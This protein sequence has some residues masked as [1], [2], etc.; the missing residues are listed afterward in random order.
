MREAKILFLAANPV[1]S[2]RLSLDEGVR[3][4]RERIQRRSCTISLD[5]ESHWA[6]RPAD[7]QRLLNELRPD[8][9]HFSG[10][11]GGASGLMFH[12]GKRSSKMIDGPTLRELF[13]LFREHVRIVV[14]NACYSEAQAR[15]ISKEIDWVVGM[16][17]AVGDRAA[18]EFA[19]GFYQALAYGQN[20]R[21]AVEQGRIAMKLDGLNGPESPCLLVRRGAASELALGKP[22]NGHPRLLLGRRDVIAKPSMACSAEGHRR[23]VIK[24]EAS[25]SDMDPELVKELTNLLRE[26]TGDMTLTIEKIEE[27]SVILTI[28]TTEAGGARLLELRDSGRLQDLAGLKVTRVLE[29]AAAGPRANRIDEGNQCQHTDTSADAEFRALIVKYLPA[30]RLLAEQLCRGHAN[31]EDVLRD[32]ITRAFEV[33]HLAPDPDRIRPWLLRMVYSA[34]VHMMRR[35]RRRVSAHVGP[36]KTADEVHEP[37]P[38]RKVTDKELHSELQVLSEDVREAY[39]L[40]AFEALSYDE[41]AAMMNIPRWLVERHIDRALFQLY[42]AML[43]S[44]SK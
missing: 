6:V 12:N 33:R 15:E 9:V 10:H 42:A 37:P 28:A 41:I 29:Q 14:L 40:F 25:L 17:R 11:G 13:K 21:N 7:V 23:Y 36:D 1:S 30:V 35:H 4:V 18:V 31:A 16:T 27:G 19:S 38:W 5:L 8:V 24:L 32:A 26:R 22:V 39:G 44:Q 2:E 3:D 20:V 34:F 43:D